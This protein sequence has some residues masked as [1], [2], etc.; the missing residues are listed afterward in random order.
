MRLQEKELEMQLRL[1]ELEL[2][3]VPSSSHVP[4]WGTTVTSFDVS[5]HI[6]F[7]PSFSKQEVDKFFLHFEKVAVN[8]HRAAEVKAMLLQSVHC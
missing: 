5:K 2:S 4:V 3:W 8:L 7:V 6:K 1:K